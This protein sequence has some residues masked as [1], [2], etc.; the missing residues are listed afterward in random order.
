[1]AIIFS[2][3]SVKGEDIPQFDIPSIDKLF[4]FVEYF[5]LG[6]L[7]VRAFS[8][9]FANPNFKYILAAS[10]LIALL[11]GST[12]EFHQRFVPGRS[13]DFFDLLSDIV[14][15]SIGACLALYKERIRECRQ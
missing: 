11:Y 7:L 3:S 14:G 5:I 8:N 12:D 13:C 15:S 6:I 10:I 9:S 4:H 2:F 1:M